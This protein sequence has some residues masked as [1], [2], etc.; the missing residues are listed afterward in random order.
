MYAIKTT[1]LGYTINKERLLNKIN[2]LVPKGAIYGFLGPNGAGKTTTIKLLLG[3]LRKQEGEVQIFGK[4]FQP[5][6][7]P[8]LKE[9]GALIESPSLYPNLTAAEHLL[10]A[11]KIYR[12]P[13]QR[14]SE[15]LNTVGL[16][17]T[18]NKKAGRFSL[19]MKQRLAIAI[20]LIHRPA[21]LILDEPTNGLDPNGIIEIRALLTQ[22]NQEQGMTLLVSS[23]M[24]AEVEK[25]VTHIGII[26]KGKM[27][28]QGAWTE[29]QA[30]QQET[31]TRIT[32]NDGVKAAAIAKASGIT[33]TIE[34]DNIITL[35][36]D[37]S[38]IASLNSRLTREALEVSQI[39]TTANDLESI[40]MDLLKN[41]K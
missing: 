15:V 1:N 12:C 8:I 31:F 17:D 30:K 3:L 36:T 20:A 14:I 32:T 28:F 35:L 9:T 40:F 5:N 2:L 39:R 26:D 37:P 11:Q 23:H 41:N 34:Q 24:L 4:T 10:I 18:G 25:L 27:L 19:G 6:R 7:I 33:V 21:L 38:G 29:L 16:S 22:L 13:R